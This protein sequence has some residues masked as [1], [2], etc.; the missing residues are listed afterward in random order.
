MSETIKFSGHRI[1]FASPAGT[2]VLP[3]YLRESPAMCCGL[4][5]SA[6]QTTDGRPYFA[7]MCV[8]AA[9][10]PLRALAEELARAGW[11][12]SPLRDGSVSGTVEVLPPGLARENK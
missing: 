2:T 8:S 9:E 7:G 5:V 4:Y 3:P 11:A 12:V 10:P 6:R 1:T